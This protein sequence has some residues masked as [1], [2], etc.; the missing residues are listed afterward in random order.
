MENDSSGRWDIPFIIIVALAAGTTFGRFV[1]PYLFRDIV[2]L[3][4]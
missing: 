1:T 3:G 2:V 4:H